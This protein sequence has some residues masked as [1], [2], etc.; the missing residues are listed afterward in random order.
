MKDYYAILGLGPD[1][2]LETI[3]RAYRLKARE[4]HPDLVSHL[5]EDLQA[6][7]TALMSELNEAYRTLSNEE[8][9]REYDIAWRALQAGE[10][11]PAAPTPA[12]VTA[13][14]IA[15]IAPAPR[16]EKARPA[17]EVST[18]VIREFADRMRKVLLENKKT[19]QWKEKKLDGFDWAVEQ[20]FF[21]DYY[22]VASRTVAVADLESAQKFRAT[23]DRAIQQGR[24]T[25]K[26]DYFLFL[27]AF[28]G[29]DEPE[30]VQALLRRYQPSG[31]EVKLQI[32]LMDVTYG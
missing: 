22:C 16:R 13:E 31:R 11:L 6:E 5:G 7:A 28:Q 15:D 14:V 32:A 19:F 20:A 4:A 27:L 23:A 21:M 24:H 9:R 30:Q 17:S 25:F 8:Q 12:P 3:K 26:N 18:S 2:D 29:M 10:P 1:A